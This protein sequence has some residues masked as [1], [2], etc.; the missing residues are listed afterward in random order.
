MRRFDLKRHRL[1][2][3]AMKKHERFYEYLNDAVFMFVGS[4]IYSVSVSVF[5]APNK[6]APGG[7]TGI[8]T[9]LHYTFGTPIG[10]MIFVLNI[11]LFILGMRFIGGEFLI[12]TVICTAMVSV[13]TDLLVLLPKQYEYH[14][15]LL[16]AALYGGVI[17]GA[18]LGLVFLRGST[19][20]GTDIASKLIRLKYRHIP[21]GRVMMFIDFL[22]VA[23]AAVVFR[24]VDDALYA[25]IAIFTGSRVIDSILYGSDTG[26]MAIVVSDKN[27]EIA[28]AISQEINRGVTLLKGKGF[29]TGRER[30]VLMC[31]VRRPEAARL[32]TIVRKTDPTAFIIMCEAGE[33]IGEGFKPITKED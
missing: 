6:I 20:G 30:D 19:T 25:M 31:A 21:M 32:R 17:S 3:P 7:I 4:A 9:I 29:Y 5:M 24:S 11:P 27:I 15:N 33:V 8:S 16:L 22:V 28:Q 13:F 18:G 26:R 10:T 14:G 23:A 2:L 12:K 1:I